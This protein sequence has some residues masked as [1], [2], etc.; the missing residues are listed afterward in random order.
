MATTYRL[1]VYN[2]FDADESDDDPYFRMVGDSASDLI[3][4]FTATWAEDHGER[5]ELRNE[6]VDEHNPSIAVFDV[7]SDA[8]TVAVAYLA[9]V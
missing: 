4:A 3:A 6:R 7:Y 5:V 1:D 2:E 9:T 8:E